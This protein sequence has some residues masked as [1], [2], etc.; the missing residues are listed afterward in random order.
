LIRWQ[1]T[2]YG[3]V[4]PLKFIP[5][6]E[7]TRLII[8]LGKWILLTAC[9]RIVEL[10]EKYQLPDIVLSVNISAIQIED[11]D[12]IF[13]LKSVLEL[14]GLPPRNLELEITESVMIKSLER[15]VRFLMT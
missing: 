13:M 7:D 15:T 8:P 11:P 6:A 5:V 9:K 1:S 12:F 4:T 2:A 10:M 14:S 3:L